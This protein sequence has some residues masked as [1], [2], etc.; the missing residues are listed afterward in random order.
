M[1][2]FSKLGDMNKIAGQAREIQKKQEAFQK[3][4]TDALK[5]LSGQ[6]DEVLKLL[7]ERG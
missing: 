1:F 2:D 7:K 6:M 5:R 4:T 3:E